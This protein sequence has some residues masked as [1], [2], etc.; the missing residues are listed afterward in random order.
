MGNHVNNIC[1]KISTGVYVV[2]RIKWVGTQEAAKI[3]YYALVESHIRYGLTIWGSSSGN[4]KR[5]L[6]STSVKPFYMQTHMDL[7][8]YPTR[9]ASRFV[10]PQHR[11]ALFEKNPSYLG[12]KLKN[13]LPDHL[14]TLTGNRLKSLLKEFLLK[15]PVYK[16]EEFLELMNISP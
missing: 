8:S 3:T 5:V 16:I 15:N 7:H 12:Q 14:R 4:L 6:R 11:T 2:K 9:H 1:N 10:L 13:L